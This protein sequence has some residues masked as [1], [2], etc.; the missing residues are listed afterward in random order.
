MVSVNRYGNASA[1]ALRA[2]VSLRRLVVD[3]TSVPEQGN[4]QE[5][6]RKKDDEE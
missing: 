5:R 1:P 6:D 3:A 4:Q 2:S